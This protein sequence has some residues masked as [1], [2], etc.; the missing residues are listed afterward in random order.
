MAHDEGLAQRI[1]EHL[2]D[3]AD[4]TE[5]KMFG[6]LAFMLR[7]NMVAG[8]LGDALVARV[9]PDGTAQALAQPHARPFDFTGKPMK[10]YVFVAPEGI[11]SDQALAGWLGLCKAFVD[12]LPPK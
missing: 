5:R 1:R 8:V 3:Q 4:V 6:G 10:G 7:G 9:G 2:Q 12:G 11:A